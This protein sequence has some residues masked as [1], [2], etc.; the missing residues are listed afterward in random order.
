[1]CQL[2]PGAAVQFAAGALREGAERIVHAQH[3]TVRGSDRHADRRIVERAREAR[4]A[5]PQRLVRLL[6]IGD[7]QADDQDLLDRAGRLGDGNVPKP[8]IP[9]RNTLVVL[10][11]SPA[12][13]GLLQMRAHGGEAIR[14]EDL[15]ERTVEA[16]GRIDAER[17]KPRPGGETTPHRSI[18][19]PDGHPRHRVG[20]LAVPLQLGL[21][22]PLGLETICHHPGDRH[23]SGCR[24]V[25]VTDGTD[26]RLEPLR[27]A[28]L[29]AGTKREVDRLEPFAQA[30]DGGGEQRHVLRV[31]ERLRRHPADELGRLE[32]EDRPAGLGRQPY[33]PVELVQRDHVHGRSEHRL[34]FVVSRKCPRD[35]ETLFHAV[36]SLATCIARLTIGHEVSS[37]FSRRILSSA[38]FDRAGGDKARPLDQRRAV[39][40]PSP[41]VARRSAASMCAEYTTP[42]T[43]SLSSTAATRRPTAGRR[44]TAVG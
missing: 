34:E 26:P 29:G 42:T 16:R 7:F 1:M 23:E 28:G 39:E 27:A 37:A 36:P 19:D 10:C 40:A 43:W 18:D 20:D 38:R 25:A 14:T 21:Q 35:G 32:A 24:A 13:E 12:G 6:A 4:L 33:G 9:V 31:D 11:R 41:V 30:L 15:A 17:R 8:E 22:E 2:E 5:A 44:S 3:R